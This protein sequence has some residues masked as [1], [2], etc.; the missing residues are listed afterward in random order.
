MQLL[1]QKTRWSQHLQAVFCALAFLYLAGTVRAKS[2]ECQPIYWEAGQFEKR[3]LAD[4]TSALIS[5]IAGSV[6]ISTSSAATSTA[7]P[8]TISPIISDGDVAPGEINCRYAANTGNTDIN[9]Y[10]CTALARKYGIS[11]KGFFRLNP[12]LSP[13]CGNIKANTD[14]C[15]DGFIEPLRATDGLCGPLHNNATCLGTPLQCCNSKTWK[16]GK[17]LEDCADGICFE[18]A[19][20]GDSVYTTDGRCGRDN[21]FKLCA[22]V[23]GDCC[24]AAGRCGTGPSFCAYGVC[25]MGNCS[26]SST[27]AQT[28]TS[29]VSTTKASTTFSVTAT[30][31]TVK[32]TSTSTS[33]KTT[34]TTKTSLTTTSKSSTAATTTTTKPPSTTI[35]GLAALPSCGQ[36]CFNNMLAQYSALGCASRDGYCLCNN[37]NFKNGIRDCSNGACGTAVGSTVIAFG[38]SYCSTA[39]ATHTATTTG[40]AALPSCGQAC[41]NN[42]VAQYSALGCAS[43]LPS[44][45]CKNANFGYGLRDCANGACG[46]AAAS[47][48]I[49]FGNSYCASATAAH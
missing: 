46:T 36:T 13:D 41:F 43:P 49:A 26:L 20:A 45:L 37:V 29:N 12:E 19:C 7:V 25:Q 9:Y 42:M 21:G 34:S 5:S 17:S 2:S 22:G 35:P 28:S 24:N 8:V 38:D 40:F 1:L 27:T 15:V 44:C 39:F 30:S 47:G 23:W 10:T 14:Y 6:D 16:C 18:G 33:P 48:V 11:V 3:D 31:T 4:T 32:Q